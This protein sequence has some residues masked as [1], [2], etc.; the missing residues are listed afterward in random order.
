[1]TPVAELTWFTP[2]KGGVPV[3]IADLVV[4][5]NGVSGAASAQQD[6]E[7]ATAGAQAFASDMPAATVPQRVSTIDVAGSTVW[8]QPRLDDYAEIWVNGELARAYDQRGGSLVAG[9]NAANRLILGRAV[10]PG[11]HIQ[12][13]VFGINGP[14]SEAPPNYIFVREARLEFVAGSIAPVAVTPQEVSVRV[15]RVD[16]RI[17]A[18]DGLRVDTQG[19]FYLCARTTLYRIPLLSTGV[20][21]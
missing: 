3:V 17:D 11:Q 5:G 14:I 13:A 8:F 12:I 18:L 2:L 9:W 15:E 21:L 16:S 1:M 7:I 4:G 10:K 20:R 19:N 6:D